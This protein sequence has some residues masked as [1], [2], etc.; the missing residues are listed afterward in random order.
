MGKGKYFLLFIAL[1]ILL[2][3]M[4]VLGENYY[5]SPDGIGNLCSQLNP[6]SFQT[7]L[8]KAQAN[9]DND[10]IYVASGT[11][12]ISQTLTYITEDGDG[13]LTIQA[14]DLNNR[15]VLDGG[16]NIQIMEINNDSNLDNHGDA[17]DN[18]TI[19]GIIFQHGKSSKYGGALNVR[20]GE[21]SIIIEDCVFNENNADSWGGGVYVHADSGDIIIINSNFYGNVG[22]SGGGAF[23]FGDKVNITI[24]NSTFNENYGSGGLGGGV[25]AYSFQ[26]MITITH[27]SFSENHARAGGG[28]FVL[29]ETSSLCGNCNIAI[30]SNIFIK[31]NACDKGGGLFLSSN[32]TPSEIYNNIFSYN[33]ANS[34][35]GGLYMF[36]GKNHYGNI[37]FND[38]YKNSA[39]NNGGGI[40]LRILSDNSQVGICDNILW[41]NTANEGGNDG[42][43]LYV[44]NDYDGNGVCSIVNFVTNDIGINSNLDTG[45]SE[46]LYFKIATSSCYVNDNNIKADP[47][48]INADNGN[49]HLKS[50]SPCIDVADQCICYTPENDYEGDDRIIN[51]RPD[52][53]ADEFKDDDGDG[54][55]NSEEDLVPD[56]NDTGNGDGNG[57]NIQDSEQRYVTSLLDVS[58]SHFIT[59][60]NDGQYQQGDVRVEEPPVD[61]PSGTKFSY[62]KLYFTITDVPVKGKVTMK[63]FVP[64]DRCINSFYVKNEQ[65]GKWH[66]IATKIEYKPLYAPNKTV[67]T[68]LVV[69]GGPYDKDGQENGNISV[70]G[71]IGSINCEIVPTMDY[72]G[73]LLFSLSAI[74]LGMFFLYRKTY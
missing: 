61:G 60:E 73:E 63:I 26:G 4:A 20:I 35:G 3:T 1:L 21:S 74:I 9:G 69:D 12:N 16:N 6:C 70:E 72:R 22:S 10:I 42:D 48:F 41:E 54:I 8:T 17:G 52:I 28:T 46:D 27:N 66:N 55:G 58:G 53:G 67:I 13:E 40:Y 23:L 62:G 15:P 44:D 25:H 19:K 56:A 68:F 51:Y 2:P 71:A 50:D 59:L 30:D 33:Q 14:E 64:F 7:A 31:N 32:N 37:S 11:Y 18:I 36:A 43:D 57:D 49:F 47:R 45:Q 65:T 24:T 29:S 38:F 39:N 5:V 34:I